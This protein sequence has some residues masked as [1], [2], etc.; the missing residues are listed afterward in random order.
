MAV[1][2]QATAWPER[3]R[4]NTTLLQNPGGAAVDSAALQA[5]AGQRLSGRPTTR[6]NSTR[7]AVGRQTARRSNPESS[8]SHGQKGLPGHHRPDQEQAH[9]K[10]PVAGPKAG[11]RGWDRRSPQRAG[12][13]TAGGPAAKLWISGRCAL[14]SRQEPA[15]L[16]RG[17]RCNCQSW[18][19]INS[20][21]R[22]QWSPAGA[23]FQ[24]RR[25]S[26]GSRFQFLA[27]ANSSPGVLAWLCCVDDDHGHSTNREIHHTP[28]D[29]KTRRD[30]GHRSECCHSAKEAQA[31]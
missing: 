8:G 16:A 17:N 23:A 3:K 18:C 6:S 24:G 13:S 25:G 30:E 21:T 19:A 12:T 10:P 31:S 27:T 14:I 7:K 20:T 11:R 5:L 9:Q 2:V 1:L 26:R 29:E 4:F 15:A 22:K 28:G